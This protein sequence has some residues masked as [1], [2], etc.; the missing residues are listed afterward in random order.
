MFARKLPKLRRKFGIVFQD[1]K[2]LTR[3]HPW[4]RTSALRPPGD[5]P[6]Q[7]H[8]REKVE[9]S[10]GIVGLRGQARQVPGRVEWW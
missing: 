7:R 5:P 6:G 3:R 1:Y 2:L 10:S 9:G 4:P 8:L